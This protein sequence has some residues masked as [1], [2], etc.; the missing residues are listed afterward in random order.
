MSKQR[1]K[2]HPPTRVFDEKTDEITVRKTNIGFDKIFPFLFDCKYS[3][4]SRHIEYV[5]KERRYQRID[6][7]SSTGQNKFHH[8]GAS[9]P[10]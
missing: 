1:K 5:S 4:L 8:I 2:K 3:D 9:L 10:V 6:S 7:I